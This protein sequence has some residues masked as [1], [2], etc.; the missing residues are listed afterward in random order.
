V[1]G[2][3]YAYREEIDV[4]GVNVSE[5]ATLPNEYPLLRDQLWFAMRAW[6]KEGGALPT[7][8]KLAAEL[9][10]PRFS[11]DERQRRKVESKDQ[12]RKVL[13]RSPDRADAVALAIWEPS[14]Y[15]E[16]VEEDEDELGADAAALNGSDP[17]SGGLNPY[18][19][20]LNPYGGRGRG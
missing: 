2:H 11:F 18:A 4:V 10:A 15:R 20:G 6:L 1:L 9:T 19:G 5:R 12:L 14:A 3:L 7:D 16:P 13:K 8:A 17:Y